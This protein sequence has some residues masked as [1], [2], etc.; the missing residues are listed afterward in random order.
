MWKVT[1][2]GRAGERKFWNMGKG[3]WIVL[4]PKKSVIV[5]KKPKVEQMV[6]KVEEYELDEK[7]ERKKLKEVK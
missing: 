7:Q 2:I 1:N 5:R 4:P 3:E 6:F